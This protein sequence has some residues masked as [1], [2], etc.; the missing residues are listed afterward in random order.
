[1]AEAEEPDAFVGGTTLPR[2]AASPWKTACLDNMHRKL[3]LKP[4]FNPF[5]RPS[6]VVELL[7]D[8]DLGVFS[9]DDTGEIGDVSPQSMNM[10]VSFDQNLNVQFHQP[11]ETEELLPAIHVGSG[12]CKVT[13]HERITSQ[14]HLLLGV[15]ERNVV[16]AVSGC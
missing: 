11:F 13:P 14:Q 2:S 9:D 7:S 4:R 8:G 12:G 3:L 1:V 16:I 10:P 5:A 15:V 6:H